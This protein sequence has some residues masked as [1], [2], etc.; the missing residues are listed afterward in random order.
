M[1][2]QELLSRVNTDIV[3]VLIL[4]GFAKAPR[5]CRYLHITS[6]TT[7]LFLVELGTV[8]LHQYRNI[9]LTGMDGGHNVLS[10][11]RQDVGHH[12]TAAMNGGTEVGLIGLNHS[13]GAVV[14]S[15]ELQSG[16]LCRHRSCFLYAAAI[17]GKQLMLVVLAVPVAELS[18]AVGLGRIALIVANKAVL[19][20][21]GKGSTIA[22]S[23][24]LL[25]ALPVFPDTFDHL[26]IVFLREIGC[27]EI[28][29]GRVGTFV[30][31]ADALCLNCQAQ[32]HGHGKKHDSFHWS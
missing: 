17:H 7:Y 5:R 14:I 6:R 25:V 8:P 30:A 15:I 24:S 20:I 4:D 22:Q 28:A 26:L 3:V 23:L 27:Y 13:L 9:T 21:D 18:I 16:E 12:G 10:C 1:G 32:H 2:V 31:D 19:Y 29:D 11:L